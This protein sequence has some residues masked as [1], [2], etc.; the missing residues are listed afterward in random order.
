MILGAGAVFKQGGD[1]FYLLRTRTNDLMTPCLNYSLHLLHE[2]NFLSLSQMSPRSSTW[3]LLD[4]TSYMY[5]PTSEEKKTLKKAG[6]K[7]NLFGT[8]TGYMV[9]TGG[10][11]RGCCLLIGWPKTW[12]ASVQY[13]SRT[14][15][16]LV[17]TQKD[18]LY[19]SQS[20][21]LLF[22]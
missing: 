6:I 2:R 16:S 8:G 4:L 5:S 10:S 9:F 7:L 11:R 14:P 21:L 17:N 12:S 18:I 20:L 22:P 15:S 1:V 19:I 3:M 13:P